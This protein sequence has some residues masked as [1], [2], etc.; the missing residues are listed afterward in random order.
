[1]KVLLDENLPHALRSLLMGHEV[2]TIDYMQWKGL[3][4]GELLGK[5]AEHGFDVLMTMD[6]GLKYQFDVAALAIAVLVV[7]AESNTM[8]DLNPLAP[9]IHRALAGIQPRT[10]VVVERAR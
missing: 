10:L 5:A 2:F 3:G 4:N 6:R 7:R 9:A 8:E 1:M